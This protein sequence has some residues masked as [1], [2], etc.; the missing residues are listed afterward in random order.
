[1]RKLAITLVAALVAAPFA[2][3][4]NAG[5]SSTPVPFTVIEQGIHSGWPGGKA[6]VVVRRAST[7]SRIYALHNGTPAPFVDFTQYDVYCMFMGTSPTSGYWVDATNVSAGASSV[8]VDV[9]DIS[10]GPTCN[11]LFVLTNPYQ[12]IRVPKQ[13]GVPVNFV[14]T[15]VVTVCP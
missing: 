10:P 6:D 4:T 12:F 1:M 15:P 5:A 3:M 14:H 9:Q 13:A 8:T 11:V 2:F 7:W